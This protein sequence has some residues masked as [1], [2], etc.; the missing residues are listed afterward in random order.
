MCTLILFAFGGRRSKK[1][2][3]FNVDFS[4]EQALEMMNNR[5]VI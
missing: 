2:S 5:G 4:K 3:K 1:N